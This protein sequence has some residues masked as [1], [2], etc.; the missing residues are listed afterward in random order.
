MMI[1]RSMYKIEILNSINNDKFEQLK[2]LIKKLQLMY[3]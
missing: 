2:E 1:E 3:L